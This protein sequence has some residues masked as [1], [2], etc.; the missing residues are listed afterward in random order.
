MKSNQYVFGI[1][2]DRRGFTLIE[3]I[4]VLAVF[5][6]LSI[7]V[8]PRLINI[9]S[10]TRDNFFLLSTVIAKSFDDSFI[11]KRTNFI[12]IHC[13]NTESDTEELPHS[14]FDRQNG[15]SVAIVDDNKEFMDNP[16]KLLKYREFP[17]SFLIK[18]VILPD[19]SM[20]SSGNI[21]V[22]IYPS[23]QSSGAIIHILARNEEEWSVII[24]PYSKHPRIEKG[25]ASYEKI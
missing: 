19:G 11:N 12:I 20:H 4:V 5:S 21:F 23:G 18:K 1:R 25:Y 3:L 15:I 13:N 14:I 10:S 24:N 9:L 7:V 2:R 16:N 8:M 17:D 22:P 6:I